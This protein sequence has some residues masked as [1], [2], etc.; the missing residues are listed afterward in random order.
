MAFLSL[1]G[2]TD[3]RQ[4]HVSATSLTFVPGTLQSLPEFV[5]DYTLPI[6]YDQSIRPDYVTTGPGEALFLGTGLTVTGNTITAGTIQNIVLDYPGTGF[7]VNRISQLSVDATLLNGPI[8]TVSAADDLVFLRD[9][10]S[11]DDLIQCGFFSPSTG[12]VSGDDWIFGGAGKD[13]IYTGPGND[14]LNGDGGKDA[15]YGGDGKDKLN[16]GGGNDKLFGQG[17]VDKLYGN[18]GGDSLFGATGNDRLFGG[19]GSDDLYGG[20]GSDRLDGGGGADQ[21][22]GGGGADTFI[23]ANLSQAGDT[24]ADFSGTPGQGDVIQLSASG[25]GGGLSAGALPSADF[26]SATDNLAVDATD[27]VIYNTLDR[28][29]WF[30]ADGTGS[31]NAPVLIAT[32]QPGTAVFDV[33]ILIA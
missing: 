9:V 4:F 24:I 27:R 32:L 20:A 2:P 33:D 17:Q 15:L 14:R 8:S 29:L 3:M 21:L 10:L 25:F 12:P 5:S 28:T 13:S 22:F 26:V 23:F 1:V 30:D 18:G 31:A 6:F 16:G 11:G 7:V 19:A